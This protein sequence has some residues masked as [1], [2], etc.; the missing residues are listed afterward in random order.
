MDRTVMDVIC[1]TCNRIIE[2]T[3]TYTYSTPSEGPW[4]PDCV[5]QLIPTAQQR[6]GERRVRFTQALQIV[7][8]K[9][10]GNDRRKP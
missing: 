4:H 5:P 8:G 6:K 2:G 7:G 1:P 10:T 3:R 9:R